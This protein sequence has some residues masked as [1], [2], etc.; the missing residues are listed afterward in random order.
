MPLPPRRLRTTRSDL[1]P[2]SRD[3]PPGIRQ[4]HK[5]WNRLHGIHYLWQE[6]MESG[7]GAV[8]STPPVDPAW[9]R[10]FDAFYSDMGPRPE[11]TSLCRRNR[12]KPFSK[13]N[14]LWANPSLMPEP[15][16]GRVGQLITYRGA[17]RTIRQWSEV[18]GLAVASIY[19]R[20]RSGHSMAVALGYEPIP[21]R[22]GRQA[23]ATANPLPAAPDT[24]E[25]GLGEQGD[26]TGD[27]SAAKPEAYCSTAG[28]PSRQ[29]RA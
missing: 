17:S 13:E 26:F 6:R 19:N 5:A 20:I 3:S 8:D 2:T 29:T 12:R 16:R 1:S 14:C 11:G 7:R 23:Q 4:A 27:G 28:L 21:G 24:I 25:V 15:Q 10:S 18:T 9:L 22:K